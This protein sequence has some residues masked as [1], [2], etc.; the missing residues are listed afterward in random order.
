MIQ[1]LLLKLVPIAV[2]TG[3]NAADLWV[4]YW[5]PNPLKDARIAVEKDATV[6]DIPVGHVH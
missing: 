4:M 6:V 2:E 3:V 1:S 5:L